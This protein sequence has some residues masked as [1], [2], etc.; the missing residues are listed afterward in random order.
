MIL[1]AN[2]ALS[3]LAVVIAVAAAISTASDLAKQPLVFLANAD[4]WGFAGSRRFVRDLYKFE[5]DVSVD[6]AA[7]SSGFPL[8][9]S[10]L[11]PSTLFQ[12]IAVSDID[13]VI[14]IDQ[15][16]R[17]QKGSSLYLHHLAVTTDEQDREGL[18]ILQ[19]EAVQQLLSAAGSLGSTLVA[20]PV[21]QGGALPPTPLTSFV[22]GAQDSAVSTS[23]VGLLL[24]GY[25]E[26][27]VDPAYHTRL[28]TMHEGDD[29]IQENIIIAA[30]IILSAVFS[31]SGGEGSAPELDK[32]LT[33]TVIDCLQTNWSCPLF[34]PYYE[35]EI[36][37]IY[38]YVYDESGF[39]TSTGGTDD[40]FATVAD[41]D[42]NVDA[43]G[44]LLAHLP[45]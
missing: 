34:R 45:C 6:A 39:I 2:D 42:F 33:L 40:V 19:D 27:F 5:C 13:V 20:V 12:S 23:F 29:D 21:Q 36:K 44:M 32:D 24:S 9:L 37:N 8:C 1:G 11:Y 17:V 16:G 18:Q 28:D 10:P 38:D 7:T 3:S 41:W 25:E 30:R 15:I 43:S 31:L 26:S 14:T 22:R 35:A 4:E